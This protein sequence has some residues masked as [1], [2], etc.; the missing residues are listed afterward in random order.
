MS[1]SS[2]P[3]ILDTQSANSNNHITV[4][5]AAHVYSTADYQ[6]GAEAVQITA[7]LLA[8]TS[9][10]PDPSLVTCSEMITSAC[11]PSCLPAPSCVPSCHSQCSGSQP[12]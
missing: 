7:S 8:Y 2:N 12:I 11:A 3:V 1:V 4:L 6:D 9:L 10:V 5:V